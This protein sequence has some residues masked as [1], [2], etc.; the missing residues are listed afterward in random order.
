MRRVTWGLVVIVVIGLPGLGLAQW[1]RYP[2]ADVPKKGDGT[3]NLAAPAPRLPDGKPDFSGLWHVMQRNPCNAALNRFSGC[4]EIGGS[5]LARDLGANLPGGLPY[6]P[7]AA[8]IVKKR[9]ADDSRDDPHVRCL[10]DNPPR[11]WGLPHLNKIVHTPKLLIAL[12]EVN[13]MYRQIFIDG[14]PL[15]EDPTPGW[16]GY[17]TARW[18]GDTLVVQTSGF[19]DNLWID[20]H[21][22]P[23]SDAAKM[24]ERIRRP[25]FGS[26]EIEITVDDPK[27]YTRP[28]TV[29]MDQSI[30]LDTDL[31]DEFCLEN[32]KSY[33]RMIRSR[34]AK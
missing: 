24:T 13:A 22:S 25:N 21:G 30:E 23:M 32:E 27:V 11:H 3:P 12:Y 5:P 8:E 29:R 6:Q 7:W 28:W 20:L 16:M 17:S 33:E 34:T 4:T 9:V 15:P 10:P 19:R 26:L 14:R 1:V 18:D 2:T 31:I